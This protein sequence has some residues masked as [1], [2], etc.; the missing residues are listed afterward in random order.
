MWSPGLKVVRPYSPESG[1][2]VVVGVEDR[3]LDVFFPDTMERLRLSP[4]PE[5][6]RVVVLEVGAIVRTPDEAISEIVAITRD[7]ARLADGRV[8]PME[9]LWPVIA[10]RGVMD[11][12]DAGELDELEHVRNRLDGLRLALWRRS[13]ALPSLLGGAIELFPHQLDAAARAIKLEQVR[14]LLADEVGLGK[15]IIAHMITSAMLRMR[16]VERVII[17]APEALT[18]Q[19]LG[20]LYRKFHQVFVYLDEERAECA[21]VDY[22]DAINPFEVYPLSVVSYELL[23]RQPWLLSALA[24]SQPDLL[25]SDEAHRVLQGALSRIVP[26]L[27]A[28]TPH[29]LA[30]TATPF[31]LGAPGFLALVSAL[32]LPHTEG[33][34]GRHIV[35]CV[36]AVTREDVAT[37]PARRPEAVPIAA[38]GKLDAAD[39]RVRW[40]A[41]AIPMWRREGKRALIFVNDARSAQ[42]LAANL[43]QLT[44][45]TLF[46][47]HEA[48]DPRQRDIELSRFRLSSSPAMVTSGAGSEGRNFQF[49]DVLVHVELPD[50]PTVLEQRIGRLDRIGRV[51]DIPVIYFTSE[52]PSGEL[53]AA[54][55][56]VG[57]FA[58]AAVGAS[59][60]MSILREHLRDKKRDRAK[61][62]EVVAQV[63]AALEGHEAL[64]IFPDSHQREDSDEVLAALPQDLEALM[65]RFCVDAAE[66]V[67]LDVVEKEGQASYS[68][69]YG[70]RVVVDAIPGL[71]PEA[72]YLGTFDRQEAIAHDEL[73]LFSSGHPLVEGLIDELEDSAQGRLGGMLLDPGRWDEV[74]PSGWRGRGLYA[75]AIE[76]GE[77]RAPTLRLF[78]VAG[79]RAD[80]ALTLDMAQAEALLMGLAHGRELASSM[81]RQVTKAVSAARLDVDEGELVGLVMVLVGP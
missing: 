16:R 70:S 57:V 62:P 4:E 20:E 28:R 13:G 27:I 71:T 39:P 46:A 65:E 26:P 49:C 61:L 21:R 17:L 56:A 1:V 80:E 73:D 63:K 42:K 2:G 10:T 11:R 54:Y 8:V 59:P 64:W 51:G 31:Q 7:K 78:G 23:E 66:R 6:V 35:R 76:G 81:R 33:A 15:T 60:A 50:D 58:D 72:H 37:M 38:P 5:S 52:G 32:R 19:W 77:S 45:Q 47:F 53:A 55:E 12:L 24:Q 36:S 14:W 25:I 29:A 3:F 34:G 41:D 44:H 69:E 18:V 74:A 9:Q 43:G 30:L 22:G 40:L 48:M 79:A 68:F 67:G 75:L